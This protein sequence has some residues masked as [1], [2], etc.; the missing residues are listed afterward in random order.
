MFYLVLEATPESVSWW[1]MLRCVPPEVS[2]M[3]REG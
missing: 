2:L 3:R 1:Y